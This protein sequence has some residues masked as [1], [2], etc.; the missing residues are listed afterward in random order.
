MMKVKMNKKISNQLN[1]IQMTKMMMTIRKERKLLRELPK[2]KN[3]LKRLIIKRE[4]KRNM[5]R[6]MMKKSLSKK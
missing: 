3:L 4:V 2:R 6:A 1:M 5:A